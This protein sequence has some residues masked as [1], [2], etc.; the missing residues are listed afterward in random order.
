MPLRRKTVLKNAAIYA[1]LLLAA[2]WALFPIFWGVRTSVLPSPQIFTSPPVWVP[3]QLTWEH[4]ARVLVGGSGYFLRALINSTVVGLATVVVTLSAALFAGFTTARLNVPGSRALLVVLLATTMIPGIATLIP[5]YVLANTTGTYNTY[6]ILIA[7]HSAWRIPVAVWVVH[8]FLRKI[9]KEVEESAL[10]D[11]CTRFGAFW[12]VI[13]PLAKPGVAASALLSFIYVWQDFLIGFILVIS[14]DLHVA[15]VALYYYLD[16]FGIRWG[17]L[18]AA[19]TLT[20]IPVVVAF[21]VFQ[22]YLIYGL[23]GGAVKE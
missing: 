21:V 3:R 9:P 13:V 10:V 6:L 17:E 11:G 18:M 22:R 23:T 14:R 4:Y 5:L 1:G 8:G 12:R 2:A 20:Y 16:Q 15:P 7:V 19:T